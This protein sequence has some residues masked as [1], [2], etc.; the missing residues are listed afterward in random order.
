MTK[1]ILKGLN[2]PEFINEESLASIFR[3]SAKKR[4]TA[5]ALTFHKKSIT[6]EELDEWSDSIAAFLSNNNIGSGNYIGVWLP[7]GLE[8]HVTILGITK[9]GA[10]YVPMDYEIPTERVHTILDE[11]GA[12]AIFTDK[13][14]N[15]PCSVYAP[16]QQHYPFDKNKV[17]SLLSSDDFAYVLYTSGS[18]GKPKG[19][20]ITQKQICHLI[21][22]EQSIFNIKPDDKV[23]QGFSVSFDMWCEET[24]LSYLAGASLWVADTIT[25][26]SIDEL[27]DVLE[28]EKI[29][30][31]HAVPSLLAAMPKDAVTVRLVNAG[32]EACTPKALKKWAN[33]NRLF[34]NSYGPT[35]TTVTATM[36]KLNKD[37]KITIGNVLPNYSLAI[38]DEQYNPVDIGTEGELI[39]SGIGVAKGYIK[40]PELTKEKFIDKPES[41]ASLYGEKIYRTGDLAILND[42]RNIEFIGRIDDQIKLHGYRIELGEIES[43]L[44]FING[45]KEAACKII[46][47]ANAQEY[48]VAFITVGALFQLNESFIKNE[49]A[50]SLPKYMIPSSIVII[51]KIPRLASGKINRKELLVP[52]FKNQKTATS[53]IDSSAM[54]ET[55]SEKVVYILKKIMPNTD[56]SL[57]Y[58]FFDKIGGDSFTTAVFVSELR[59][60]AGIPNASIKDVYTHRPLIKLVE[61]WEKDT[62]KQSKQ[63]DL[64]K[65]Q[66]EKFN[67]ANKWNYFTCGIA[68]SV[69]LLFI[70]AL[71]AMQLFLP[72]LGYSYVFSLLKSHT[73]AII[74]AFSL[75]CINTPLFYFISIFLKWVI[76]GKMK[77]GD[78]PLWGSYYFRWWF[79]KSIQKLVNVQLLS[80][81]PL[82]SIYM[83]WL[84]VKIGNDAQLS[85]LKIGA[86]DLVT[87]GKDVSISSNVVLDNAFIEN[88]WLKLRKIEIGDHAYIGSSA[89]V[90][91]NTKM[92]DWSELQDLSALLPN[93]IIKSKEVW[94]GSPAKKL[95]LKTTDE[96]PEPL[97]VSF[98]TKAN[99]SFLYGIIIMHFP[100]AMIIPILPTIIVLNENNHNMY[101]RDFSYLVL[102]PILAFLYIII[103][104]IQTIVCS[105]IL[106]YNIKP[107]V[108]KVYSSLY[109]RKWLS[110]QFMSL[111]LNVLH[112]IY[113]TIYISSMFRAFGAKIGKKTEISTA[114]GITHPLLEIGEGGFIADA[115]TLGEADIRGLRFTLKKTTIKNMSFVGNAA[116][117]PQGYELDS[118]MLIGVL[119]T[120]PSSEQIKQSKARDWFGSPAM[121]LPRRQSNQTFPDNLTINPSRKRIVIRGIVEF[122]RILLP[123]TVITL[124]CILFL[125]FGHDLIVGHTVIETILLFPF[126]YLAL[127][128]IPCFLFT[129]MLKWIIIGK[130]HTQQFPM[131]TW[132]V[133]KSEAITTTYEALAIPFLLEFLAGTFWLPIALRMLGVKIGKRVFMNTTDIT[134][135]DVVSI[136]DD[137]ILN[138]DCGPQ[139]HLF[140]DRIMKIG[141]V[142]I[143]KRCTIGART[144][145]LY[146]SKI[147]DDAN[148]LPLS[149][150]MKGET[151]SGHKNWVGSPV[152]LKENDNV[153]L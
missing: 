144:I 46:K 136:G 94:E 116:V 113:A 56:I 80:D 89:V 18:T 119:S 92:E 15:L 31:F 105:R 137:S 88:G 152:R 102:T 20:P 115:A 101:G 12:S 75:Y 33:A 86:E 7:R 84:G 43:K 54:G 143:G 145:I 19:I 114:S 71:F 99:Y 39:I 83:K 37:D 95:R 73:Y 150:V 52:E 6:Y 82:Y 121:A 147:E 72:Y 98:Y 122:I 5:T 27:T 134:E 23:Y 96:L 21:R 67:E 28:R 25:A 77:E 109:L 148:I 120:P 93:Q 146:D 65:E 55:V 47:D 53:E 78:Y 8:L 81:T 123:T 104:L 45:I 108:Y 36:A 60:H 129:V 38:V 149:L 13:P 51:D 112:P 124:C 24:W 42:A 127:I 1:S 140:E 59:D 85:V 66:N 97:H 126:Y 91:P 11:V 106:Q 133:W 62:E 70:C 30:I 87:M 139:T 58:D 40:N 107:G 29:T 153:I 34:Y 135:Y 125:S 3:E 103:F 4:R 2:I 14:I 32:G 118:N 131:W 90:G 50:K 141:S 130:Y 48:L 61:F 100:L 10:T 111:S 22:A 63:A 64:N 151:I 44:A 74:T 35:E 68:Q 76:I 26:K 138:E 142:S 17:P 128:G 16:L 9:S 41:L 57:E 110:D 117:I 69:S 79:V 49:L 132:N